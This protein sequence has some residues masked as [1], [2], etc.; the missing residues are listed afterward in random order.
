MLHAVI[1][2]DHLPGN[3]ERKALPCQ[4]REITLA[5]LF[6]LLQIPSIRSQVPPARIVVGRL[7]LEASFALIILVEEFL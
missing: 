6:T 5:P 1:T 4:R 3:V 2:I 7:Q